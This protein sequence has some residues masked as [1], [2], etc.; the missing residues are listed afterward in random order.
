MCQD[1]SLSEEVTNSSSGTALCVQSPDEST[2]TRDP[3]YIRA[4]KL[5]PT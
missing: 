1:R 4:S 5:Y 2:E 3:K